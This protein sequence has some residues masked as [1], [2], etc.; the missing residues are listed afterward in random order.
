[1]EGEHLG[2]FR[3]QLSRRLL[4]RITYQVVHVEQELQNK[5]VVGL[6]GLNAIPDD[7]DL[8]SQVLRNNLPPYQ[9]AEQTLQFFHA[10]RVQLV[11]S[12]LEIV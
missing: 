8:D 6:E 11:L 3:L 7:V 12:E 10:L 4:V 9:K 1:M 5:L 2:V